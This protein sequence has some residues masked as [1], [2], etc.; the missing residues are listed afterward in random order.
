MLE[1]RLIYKEEK[2]LNDVPD[3]PR[4]FYPY[5]LVNNNANDYLKWEYTYFNKIFKLNISSSFTKNR[6]NSL[7]I[8]DSDYLIFK[9]ITKK[10]IKNEL[11]EYL[12]DYL[13]IELPYGSLTGVRPTKLYYQLSENLEDPMSY[14]IDKL[15]VTPEKAHLIKDVVINQKGYKN[16][17]NDNIS[18]FINIPF[19]PTRCNYCSFISTEFFRIK[20]QIPLYLDCL[21][22]DIKWSI[23]YIKKINKNVK[24]IYIGG[25]TPTV[26]EASQLDDLLSY[27]DGFDVE[28]TV[29]A[30]RP[31]TITKEKL[32]V[33]KK[34]N[35]TRISINPQTFNQKTLDLIGRK[36]TVNDVI[37]ALNLSKEYNF[38]INMDLIAGLT[39]ETINDFKFSIS[40]ALE[41][42][43][44]NITL[45]SLSI[46]RGSIY[47]LIDKEKDTSGIAASMIS[48]GQRLL[49]ENDYVPYYMY[50]Q[51][52]MSD[53]IENTGFTIPGFQ[54]EYNIDMMEESITIIGLGAGAMNK[55]VVGDR[56]ERYANPKGFREY[57][58]RIDATI[59]KKTDFFNNYLY[60]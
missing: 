45:H 23:S 35:V 7:E 48:Y 51:K 3:I 33:L 36:H 46:K 37:N 15:H 53:N 16:S 17:S 38:S 2:Y 42:K 21:K 14:L 4:A 18:L 39:D 12:S 47:A 26:L 54:C 11:Y 30:G 20:N 6:E 52:D 49:Y 59:L 56:V 19:C 31:D 34:H 32:D 24:S 43:P 29:E 5:L 44:Q 50:R 57:C 41:F 27:I 22:K 8:D 58:E 60:L 40:K 9:R 25:G 55:I 13:K 1:I 28:F 10:F